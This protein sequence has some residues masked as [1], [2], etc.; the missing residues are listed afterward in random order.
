MTKFNATILL[1][2]IFLSSCDTDFLKD[3]EDPESDNI[4]SNP[5]ESTPQSATNRHNAI[6]AEVFDKSKV[7]WSNV[8]ATS[9]QEY[10][11]YLA[12]TGQLEHDTTDGYGENLYLSTF[13]ASYLDAINCWYKEKS[14]YHYNSNSCNDT[15]GHYTQLVWKDTTEIGCGKAIYTTGIH[16]NNTVIVCRYNPPGNYIGEQPY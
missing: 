4:S 7:V 12:S 9:A 5:I 11:N 1:L 16:K 8:V 3:L 10:A 14:D 15:C 6:R 2:S 13:K